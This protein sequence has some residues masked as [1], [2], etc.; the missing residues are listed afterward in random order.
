[1]N[2]SGFSRELLPAPSECDEAKAEHRKKYKDL[3]DRARKLEE[4][5]KS[6]RE[7]QSKKRDDRMSELADAYW[8]AK[9]RGDK[10]EAGRLW[11]EMGKL[12]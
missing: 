11:D 5:E 12:G 6:G 10:E 9:Q 8:K 2:L 3:L 7:D 1:M 4:D